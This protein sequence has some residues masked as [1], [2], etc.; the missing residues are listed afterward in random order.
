MIFCGERK[1]SKKEKIYLVLFGL[2]W[3]FLL[4]GPMARMRKFQHFQCACLLCY[5]VNW[6]KAGQQS[7]KIKKGK[8]TH[9]YCNFSSF[10][11]PYLFDCYLLFSFL[12]QFSFCTQFSQFSE[13]CSVVSDSLQPHGYTVHG[14]LLAR[15]TGVGILTSRE[16]IYLDIQGIFPTQEQNRGLP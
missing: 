15:K 1:R 9:W 13:S 8:E 3:L 5:F 6:V 7:L 10:Y 11:F 16:S 2:L 4:P 12:G 14:I